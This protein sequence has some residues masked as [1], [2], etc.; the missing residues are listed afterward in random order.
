[1]TRTPEANPALRVKRTGSPALLSAFTK[2]QREQAIRACWKLTH[3]IDRGLDLTGEIR[4]VL[5]QGTGDVVLTSTRAILDAFAVCLNGSGT[6][7]GEKTC[8]I[9]FGAAPGGVGAGERFDKIAGCLRRLCRLARSDR[10]GWRES[11][12]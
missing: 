9:K 6:E 5:A 8:Y 12:T 10:R 1:M 4:A 11:G 3:K 7:G 2:A